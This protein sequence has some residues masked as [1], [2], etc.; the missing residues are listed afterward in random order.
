MHMELN[1]PPGD[2]HA[3]LEKR[4]QELRTLMNATKFILAFTSISFLKEK[5]KKST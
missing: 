2:M 1:F 5:E 4:P 3:V